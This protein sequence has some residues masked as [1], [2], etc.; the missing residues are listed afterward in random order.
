MTIDLRWYES[1]GVTP[2]GSLAFAQTNGTPSTAQKLW[3]QNDGTEDAPGVSVTAL[4]REQGS[5]DPYSFDDDMAA[6]RWLEIRLTGQSAGATPHTTAWTPI[7]KGRRLLTRSIPAGEARTVEVRTNIP[8]G[9]GTQAKDILLRPTAASAVV[10]LEDAPWRE[11]VRTLLGDAGASYIA[12]GGAVTPTG[13]PDDKV[14]VSDVSWV[15]A[16]EP[17]ALAGAAVALSQTAGDGALGS[18][19]YYWAVLSL[20]DD[21]TLTT[22]K[23]NAL[24]SPQSPNDRP[25]APSGEL[26][27]ADV[28]VDYDAGGGAIGA[29]D[30]LTDRRESGGFDLAY[31]AAS[32]S[33]EVAPGEAV[34]GRRLVQ[35]TAAYDLDLTASKTA[36][37]V[38]GSDG[39][40]ATA[41]SPYGSEVVP[42]WEVTTDGTGVTAVRDLRPLLPLRREVRLRFEVAGTLSGSSASVP[43]LITVPL[44]LAPFAPL[45]WCVGDTGG[46]SGQTEI[47]LEVSAAGGGAWTSLG[48]LGA[49]LAYD[50]TDPAATGLVETTT[51]AA[52]SRVR[53]VV[54]AVPGTASSDLSI[55]LLTEEA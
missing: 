31:S 47:D 8:A 32:L 27:L 23:G 46:T 4:T 40:P 38:L 10:P 41:T 12:Q 5:S 30:I 33:V 14:H 28:A 48:A 21:G 9:V 6:N 52:G 45:R 54:G 22:T 51:L 29:A 42:L 20:K 3:L 44:R 36:Y 15:A 7:G 35:R 39:A 50:A 11:G 18:G 43:Q 17:L 13:T 19:G 25:D 49:A 37:V 24:T 16:G 2:A 1:D 55:E 53:A 34:V 26:I